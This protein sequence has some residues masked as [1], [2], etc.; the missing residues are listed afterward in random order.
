MDFEQL[1]ALS[2]QVGSTPLI[3]LFCPETK[4]P[5]N[6]SA[7]LEYINPTGSHK[8]R[9]SLLVVEDCLSKGLNSVGCASSGNF[10][11]SLAYFA[12]QAGLVCHI[13]ISS[14]TSELRK[15][16]LQMY[17]PNIHES[18]A[19]LFQ[20]VSIS[21][22]IMSNSDIYNAN[23]GMCD[24][25][26]YAN[27]SIAMEIVQQSSSITSIYACVNNGTHLLGLA[28]ANTSLQ[29]NGVYTY[30]PLAASICG[31][32]KVEGFKNINDAIS[33]SSGHLHEAD[34]NDISIGQR[35]AQHNG[36]IIENAS[37]AT[38][39]VAFRHMD[40]NTRVCCV[41]TG[42]GMKY[43]DEYIRL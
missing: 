41:L 36:L 20:L 35:I 32:S 22:K 28:A 1:S 33:N 2:L 6:I 31:F 12:Q 24:L 8:D 3:D 29:I 10:A 7:K 14:H 34:I 30:E 9:E 37:A 21:D 43:P 23:P 42:S 19:S 26:S 40:P 13:W 18:E 16:L 27:Q 15:T 5:L 25:K 11:L 39:G 38:I 17:K 4:R